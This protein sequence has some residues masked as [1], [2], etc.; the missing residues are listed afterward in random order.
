M[1]H[2][3][4]LSWPQ[5]KRSLPI[6]IIGTGGPWDDVD[7]FGGQPQ[8]VHI[9]SDGDVAV[10]PMFRADYLVEVDISKVA[11]ALAELP[12]QILPP[13]PDAPFRHHGISLSEWDNDT[14]LATSALG[15]GYYLTV[16]SLGSL[17]FIDVLDIPGQPEAVDITCDGT[18]AVVETSE[19]LVWLDMMDTPPAIIE[20][21]DPN[22]V[23]G[24]ARTDLQST[25]SVA[26]S[27]DGSLLFVAGYIRGEG[28]GTEASQ[29]A[30]YD[31]TVDPPQLI[32]SNAFPLGRRI[33]NVAT[34]PCSADLEDTNVGLYR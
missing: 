32:A 28:Q 16:A 12:N 15:S 17:S 1:P 6:Q 9:N 30:V 31:A 8:D 21:D 23:F 22:N 13:V 24:Q 11:P 20:T 14:I 5:M 7:Y 27:T 34:L 2:Q 26:F 3:F 25:S 19:G 29:I 4:R 33:M 18:R 10:Q